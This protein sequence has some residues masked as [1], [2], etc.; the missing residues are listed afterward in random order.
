MRPE[1]YLPVMFNFCF[2]EQVIFTILEAI[3]D[4]FTRLFKLTDENQTVSDNSLF[5]FSPCYLFVM[6]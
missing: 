5:R 2:A 1:P 6:F 4:S 3:K